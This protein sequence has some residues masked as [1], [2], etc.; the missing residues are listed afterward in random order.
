M[1]PNKEILI[2]YLDHQLNQEDSEQIEIMARNDKSLAGELQFM[3]LAIDTVRLNAINN[4]VLAIRGSLTNMQAVS[5]KPANSKVRSMYKMSLRVAAVFILLTGS[6]VLYKYISVSNLSVYEKQF[7]GYELNNTRG[8]G[9]RDRKLKLTGIKTGMKLW[10]FIKQ[11]IINRI[12]Q[13]SWLPWP[14]C[15]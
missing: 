3:K 8:Q 1:Q 11:K 12:S 7:T 10:Q 5:E 13:S 15:S 14:K 2:D 6:A 9:S 4:K